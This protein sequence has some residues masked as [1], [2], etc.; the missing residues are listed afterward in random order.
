MKSDNEIQQDALAELQWESSM[1]AA[2][3]GVELSLDVVPLTG[4]LCSYTEEFEAE[5]SAQRVCGGNALS[6]E[7][8]VKLA[9]SSERAA[10]DIA[11]SV[12]SALQWSNYLSKDYVKTM[13]E[14][15]VAT[16]T[17]EVNWESQRRTAATAV[18]FLLGVTAVNE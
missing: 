13:V 8:D 10:A 11:A 3:I 1:R 14:N 17:G 12:E 4:H 15:G 5:H 9:G 6:E 16:I 18:R 7:I 2:A